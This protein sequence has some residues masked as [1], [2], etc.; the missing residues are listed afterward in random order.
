MPIRFID[1]GVLGRSVVVLG[2]TIGGHLPF[3]ILQHLFW[4][5]AHHMCNPPCGVIYNVS[6]ILQIQVYFLDVSEKVM[7]VF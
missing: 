1:V 6:E 2:E 5:K 3:R 4:H 7:Y